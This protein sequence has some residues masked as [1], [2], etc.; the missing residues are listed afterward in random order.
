MFEHGVG[1]RNPLFFIGAVEDNGDKRLEGRIKVRAFGIH[2]TKDQISTDMLPWAIVAQGGYDANVVPKI[3]SW[4]YGMFLD[5]RDAQQPMV[6]GLI[7]T[8]FQNELNPNKDGWGTI[9]DKDGVVD[10]HGSA[11]E[12]R[13]QPQNDRLARGEYIQETYVLQQEMGRTVD[14]PIAGT[15]ESWDEPAS[16]YNAQYPKNRVIATANHSIELDD[17]P[18]SERIMI[19]H[20]SG[21][22][23][24]I[25]NRGTTTTKAVSDKYDIMDRKQHVV[26]GGM[27]TVTIL[28]NSYVY[29]KGDKVEEIEGNLQT[30]VHGDHHLSVGGQSTINAAEQVQVRGADVKVEANVG[31]MSI[32]AGKELN[33]SAGGLVGVPPKYGAISIKAEKVMVDATDKLHLRGNTQVN[34]Q[35]IAEMNI[36]AVAINQL[37][38]TWSAHAS[39]ATLISST[40]TTD[41]S[42][43]I[44]VAIGGGALTSM[45]SP[46][47]NV[48]G[49][50]SSVNLATPLPVRPP[51]PGSVA[52]LAKVALI[53][54]PTLPFV[55]GSP[56]PELAFEAGSCAA[57]EPVIKS[58]SIFPAENQGSRGSTGFSSRDHGSNGNTGGLSTITDISAVTQTAITPLLD[59]IGNKESEGYDDISGLISNS[60]YPAKPI[61]EMT[62]QEILDWQESIDRFQLSEAVGRYQIIEDTLRGYNNDKTVGPGSPLYIRAGLNSGSLYS[63]E[64]QDKMAIVLIESRGLSMFL[65]GAITRDQFAN[66]LA[67]EW[68]SLPLVS[69]P[70][71]GR[72]NY[73]KDAA[74]NRALTTVQAI[75]DAIDS[76][77]NKYDAP[78]GDATDT[79]GGAQ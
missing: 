52:V 43:T 56:L 61:T 47:I 18:G 9:P 50:A 74:G 54:T 15:E 7:P 53:G 69:G 39:T 72:S 28:G 75:R 37:A 60:R 4:V 20:K 77:K 10:A 40:G 31:T 17:T 58:L 79:T 64:N 70:N 46:I 73:D 11:P 55:P 23:I 30:L 16:A 26:V 41:I 71:A 51:I 63:P 19:H 12:D 59:F 24:Q 22:F 25:D 27:S 42:G 67:K 1:I 44:E 45:S 62:M 32:K 14:V 8:Q 57:P 6:L 29:V 13:S 34:I 68:A 5:G 65:D 35:S 76:V 21:S 38:A 33:I 49:S 48:G 78:P 36:S 3:N 66:N 2:G